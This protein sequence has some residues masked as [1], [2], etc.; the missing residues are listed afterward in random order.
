MSI[1]QQHEDR[2]KDFEDS[3]SK[4][5]EKDLR[6]SGHIN[7][8]IVVLLYEKS[9]DSYGTHFIPIPPEVFSTNRGAAYMDCVVLPGIFCGYFKDGLYPICFCFCG[10]IK[11]VFSLWN[12]V[13]SFPTTQEIEEMRKAAPK[14]LFVITFETEEAIHINIREFVSK[15][16]QVNDS[17]ALKEEVE[18][19]ELPVA[20]KEMINK[21][22]NKG[23]FFKIF[24]AI[25]KPNDH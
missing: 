20:L 24:N 19:N 11:I 7:P 10:V 4:T 1:I 12:D 23:K 5:F 3:L 9:K 22:Y 8:L 15:G 16:I 25:K 13:T 14:E 2:I 6:M 17:G 21:G 18:L